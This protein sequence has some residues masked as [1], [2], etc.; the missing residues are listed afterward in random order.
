MAKD[1]K[2]MQDFNDFDT[3]NRRP[4]I[5][6]SHTTNRSTVSNG[7]WGCDISEDAL[8]AAFPDT[9]LHRADRD[10]HGNDDAEGWTHGFER[11]SCLGETGYSDKGLYCS[12]YLG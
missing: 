2:F 6:S 11:R 10:Y 4:L 9:D 8:T 1:S 3:P 7:N 12:L 5:G